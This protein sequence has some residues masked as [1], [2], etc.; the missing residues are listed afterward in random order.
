MTA[1]FSAQRYRVAVLGATGAVGREMLAVL[2]AMR[3]PAED[4]VALASTRSV[5]EE[6][7]FGNRTLTVRAAEPSAFEGIDIVLASA[8]SAVSKLLLP[9][10]A[11]RGCFCIDNSSAFRMD[12][13]VPLIVPEVN[14][15]ALANHNGIVANPN[16]STIQMVVAI[17][18]LHDAARIRR[19]VVST[20]QAVSG[21]G[22][23]G[24]DELSNQSIALFNQTPFD[25]AV[26]HARIAFNVIPHIGAFDADGYT[27][28][29]T[30]LIHE[31]RKIM[32]DS[33]IQVCPTAVRVPV[34]SGHSESI[35]LEF[36]RDLSPEAAREILEMSPGVVVV[37]DPK[38]KKYPM[39]M[40]VA[41]RD[42]VFVGRI[43]RDSSVAHGL[44]MWVVA[45]N[46]RKGAAT[47]AVQI[48]LLAVKNGW[49]HGADG[50]ARAQAQ[51]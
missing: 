46:L 38:A 1:P 2:D 37:D 13:A 27:E 21:A 41:E 32:G 48:A 39:P 30:K 3:F 8:G 34:F 12:P 23:K 20:Y 49:V 14:P 51:A 33:Q 45:D 40:D 25:V 18:P 5:G 9:E 43:R 47:N 6:V 26:H 44:A 19:I 24:M 50:R 36:E 11:R 17:K 7:E 31:T 15:A 16:C 29:E 35:V 4:V 28:E 42:E 22:K 10:A